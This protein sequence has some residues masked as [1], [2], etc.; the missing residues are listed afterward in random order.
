MASTNRCI[1]SL[2]RLSLSSPVRPTPT[3]ISKTLTPRPT[4]ARWR[5]NEA[6]ILARRKEREKLKKAK[7]AKRF[8]EYR[9]AAPTKEEEQYSLLDAMRYLRAAEVGRPPSSAMYELSLRMRTVKNA[10]VVRGRI[11]FP[12]PWKN[13]TRIGVIC[14]PDSNAAKDAR[15]A[16][17]VI[18]GEEEVFELIKTRASDLPFNRLICHVDSEPALKQ[19]NL[20][21]LLGP[22]GLMPSLKTNTIVKSVSGLMRDMVGS[23]EYRERI[24]VIRIPVGNIE[25]TPKMLSTNIKA[26]M[27]VTKSGITRIEDRVN[28]TIVEVVLSSTQGPGLPLNGLFNATDEKLK[29]EHLSTAM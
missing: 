4:Q 9:Y 26:L 5:V 22:R 3:T 19:A 28:K 27:D 23:E 7:K 8:K 2:A 21:R 1:A 18:Y 20:G 25:F 14:K 24:G 17:A 16:G 12:Y 29:P 10:P 11:R 6:A 13:D 15:A